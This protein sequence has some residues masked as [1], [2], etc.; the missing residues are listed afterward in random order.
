MIII[1]KK[2][3]R[4]Y[5]IR[6]W[7]GALPPDDWVRGIKFFIHIKH[8]QKGNVRED[9]LQTFIIIKHKQRK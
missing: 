3:T 7:V 8:A 9:K 5:N 1:R 4:V 6:V 2:N